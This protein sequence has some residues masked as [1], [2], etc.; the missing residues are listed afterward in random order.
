VISVRDIIF[1]VN[2]KLMVIYTKVSVNPKKKKSLKQIIISDIKNSR[3]VQHHLA[4]LRISNTLSLT[5]LKL[6]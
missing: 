1:S 6:Q 2:V 4:N 3:G 5:D